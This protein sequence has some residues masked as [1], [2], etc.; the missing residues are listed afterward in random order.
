[1]L[2][3]E[4]LDRAISQIESTDSSCSCDI[5]RKCENC[6]SHLDRQKLIEDLN[7]M[8]RDGI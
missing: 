1:M 3:E 6:S 8:K 7:L 5:I 2:Y 4:I